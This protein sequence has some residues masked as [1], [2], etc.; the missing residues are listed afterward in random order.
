MASW[1]CVWGISLGLVRGVSL[2]S[3]VVVLEP[4]LEIVKCELE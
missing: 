4:I 1:G 3:L 2:V